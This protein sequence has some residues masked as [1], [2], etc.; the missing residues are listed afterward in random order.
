[1]LLRDV[2]KAITAKSGLQ[3]TNFA[4]AFRDS[5]VW[6][7]DEPQTDTPLHPFEIEAN[8]GVPLA[9]LIESKLILTR[10]NAVIYCIEELDLSMS[11]SAFN[12]ELTANSYF[13]RLER[14]ICRHKNKHVLTYG[15]LRKFFSYKLEVDLPQRIQQYL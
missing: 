2:T 10:T 7:V 9:S 12:A 8:H 11:Q 13:E 15:E 1:M 14:E 6:E 4:R 5:Y 3:R